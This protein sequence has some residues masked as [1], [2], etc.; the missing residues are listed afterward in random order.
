MIFS[1][2][3]PSFAVAAA[4]AAQTVSLSSDDAVT[5]SDD[6]FSDIFK[7]ISDFFNGVINSV[8]NFFR[9]LFGQDKDK[10]KYTITF[11]DSNGYSVIRTITVEEGETIPTVSIPHKSGYTFIGWTP[12]LPSKMPSYDLNVRAVWSVNKYT[13]TFDSNGGS[14]VEPIVATYGSVIN[15]PADPGLNGYRFVGWQV[16]NGSEWELTS[17]PATMPAKNISYKAKWEVRKT[18]LTFVLGNGQKDIVLEGIYGSSVLKPDDPIMEGHEFIGWDRPVPEKFPA[19][20]VTFKAVYN[21]LSYTVTF[22]DANGKKI[23]S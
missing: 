11:Y 9:W 13:L 2:A 20:D 14:D 12:A 23:V 4:D 17:L 18:Q 1:I 3:V 15:P 7:S 5:S 19:N 10:G 6:V 16:W 21:G 8:V 22:V